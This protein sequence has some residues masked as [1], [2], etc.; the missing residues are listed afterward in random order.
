MVTKVVAHLR[1]ANLELQA[2][3]V[4]GNVTTQTWL[5]G[6]V[7]ATCGGGLGPTGKLK[8]CSKPLGKPCP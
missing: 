4:D 8:P 1:G 7:C 6:Q 5:P 3:G 2:Y